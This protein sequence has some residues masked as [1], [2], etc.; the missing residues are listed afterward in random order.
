MLIVLLLLTWRL[1]MARAERTADA[2]EFATL[3]IFAVTLTTT[4]RMTGA[5]CACCRE[6]FRTRQKE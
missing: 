2:T 1:N 6:F 3:I 4:W 5:W